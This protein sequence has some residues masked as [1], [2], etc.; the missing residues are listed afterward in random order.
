[1]VGVLF[2]PNFLRN[3]VSKVIQLVIETYSKEKY[4]VKYFSANV[5]G[6]KRH[7]TYSCRML[8]NLIASRNLFTWFSDR[9]FLLGSNFGRNLSGCLGM[10]C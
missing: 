10:S 1:M 5:M 8:C 6:N 7:M 3:M 9:S 2:S 4:Q